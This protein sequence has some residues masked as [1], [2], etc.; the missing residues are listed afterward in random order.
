MSR[1]HTHVWQ[2]SKS[3]PIFNHVVGEQVVDTEYITSLDEL[4][5]LL[6]LLT[7]FALGDEFPNVDPPRERLQACNVAERT[8]P[9]LL[10][11]SLNTYGGYNLVGVD[12]LC[13]CA[14]VVS[15]FRYVCV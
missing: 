15:V 3:Y 5:E 4:S 7:K 1:A 9:V 11:V 6:W 2:A 10:V 8:G 14:C 13:V 12:S